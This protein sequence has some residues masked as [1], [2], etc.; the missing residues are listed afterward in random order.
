MYSIILTFINKSVDTGKEMTLY[1]TGKKKSYLSS[2]S[3][4]LVSTFADVFVLV[5][6]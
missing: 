3:G 1:F 4:S 5:V 2:L 6:C